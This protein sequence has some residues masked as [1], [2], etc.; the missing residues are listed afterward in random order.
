[1]QVLTLSVWPFLE[2]LLNFMV[3]FVD[4][5]LAGR[6][7]PNKVSAMEAM[8]VGAYVGWGVS[9]I[10]ISVGVGAT[11]IIAR[12][13]G[14]RHKR[15]A[16]AAL[17]QALIM[18][19]VTGAIIGGGMYFAARPVSAFMGVQ[20][21]SL[22]FSTIYL[23]VVCLAAPFS[24][25]LFVGS[26]CLRAAGDTRS[27]F[28][29]LMIV[30]IVNMLLSLMLVY[31][32]EPFGGHGVRGIATGTAIAWL[33]GAVLTIIVLLRSR[34]GM[35]LR[36][37]RL[38]PHWHTMQRIIRVGAPNLLE[39][40]TFWAG[41]F[42]VVMI[43]G[44]IGQSAEGAGA[45]A[46]HVIGVRLEAISYLPGFALG[47]AASTLM[48]QYLGLGDAERAKRAAGYC[49]LIA[50]TMMGVMGLLFW[51]IPEQLTRLVT[52]EPSLL[53][54]APDLLR[55]CAPVQVFFATAMVLS[56]A[57]RGAGAT[58]STMIVSGISTW[59]IRLPAVYLI[60]WHLG[61][62]LNGVWFALCGELIVRGCAFW[63][64]FSRGRWAKAAV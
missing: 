28:V 51:F 24:G 37:I 47:I 19:V 46:A 64:Q 54:S 2:Q 14:G 22:D 1:M 43:V 44:R 58:R 62:G 50:A 34:S 32:P 38:R 11:A 49:W 15:V 29:V 39:A 16:N 33:V 9:L 52:D 60:G 23:R 61:Y 26:A 48:G 12:A 8:S 36:F 25:I 27:P 7:E 10:Q 45:L 41:N 35:R 56:N 21:L 59:L 3:G 31:G 30:N 42:I 13:I 18:A 53:A 5:V 40:S 17:G 55:I 4:T 57:M 20:G 6:M 63:V